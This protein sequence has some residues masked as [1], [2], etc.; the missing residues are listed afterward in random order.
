M[1]VRRLASLAQKDSTSEVIEDLT[2]RKR[3]VTSNLNV[4][5]Y[6]RSKLYSQLAVIIDSGQASK[7]RLSFAKIT[8]THRKL[9][10][11]NNSLTSDP[12]S[13]GQNK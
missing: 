1:P 4:L 3:S 8:V 5:E 6:V 9:R 11:E 12:V 10:I 13:S 7:E 2:A